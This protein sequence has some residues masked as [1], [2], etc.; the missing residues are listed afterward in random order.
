MDAGAKW[1]K[2][3]TGYGPGVTPEVV[4]H[5]V[6]LARKRAGVKASG[7]IHDLE[8]AL[9]LLEA[10]AQRLGL[11]AAPALLEAARRRETSTLR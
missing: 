6:K 1:L 5:L 10:G 3:G 11:S 7:G 8:Q 9:R 4:R 2:S